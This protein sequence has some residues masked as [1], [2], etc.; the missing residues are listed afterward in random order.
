MH[1]EITALCLVT[2]DSIIKRQLIC[3]AVTKSDGELFS[4]IIF[5]T[6]KEAAK[7]TEKKIRKK[8]IYMNP[9]QIR[10]SS[11]GRKAQVFDIYFMDIIW[12]T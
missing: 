7:L 10:Y 1:Y 6:E 11:L 3:E 4:F 5:T 8:N 2:Q 12:F 9:N